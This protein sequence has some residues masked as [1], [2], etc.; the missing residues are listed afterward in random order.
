MIPPTIDTPVPGLPAMDPND[1]QLHRLSL[2]PDE[3]ANTAVLE[4]ERWLFEARKEVL[5]HATGDDVLVENLEE[6]FKHL[7][8]HKV[9]EWERQR[10]GVQLREALKTLSNSLARPEACT[11]FETGTCTILS[12][13]HYL[14][15]LQPVF[16]ADVFVPSSR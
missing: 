14:I 2:R 6:A 8:I 13:D 9:E 10:E 4:Y 7:Q 16:L 15:I 12:A 3:P 11:S 1:L 5:P